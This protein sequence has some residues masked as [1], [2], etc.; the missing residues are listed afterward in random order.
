MVRRIFRRSNSAF[1][2]WPLGWFAR[3]E[4]KA[5]R[6]RLLDSI[7]D[8]V[9]GLPDTANIHLP[10]SRLIILGAGFSRPAGLPLA[11]GLLELVRDNLKRATPGNELER[12]IAEWRS[13][14]PNERLDLE[15]VLA[16]SH[17]RHHLRLWGPDYSEGHASTL[18]DDVQNQIQRILIGSTPV[19]PEIPAVYRK[20]AGLLTE[21]DVVLTF[22]YDTILEETLKFTGKPYSLVPKR[23]L[24]K[25]SDDQVGKPV[26]ILKLHGSVDWYD[27][28]YHDAERQWTGQLGILDCDPIF[29]PNP[30]V[31]SE[32]LSPGPFLQQPPWRKDNDLLTRVVRVPGL[33]DNFLISSS[34]Y[35]CAPFLLPPAHDKLLG[36]DPITDIWEGI[37]QGLQLFSGIVIIGYSF[38]IYDSYA[39]EGLG[40]LLLDYQG[41]KDQKVYGQS[42][43]PI[44][45]I[46]LAESQD[47]ALRGT[48]FL[49]HDKTR[50]WHK[51][52]STESVDWLD[53]GD[54]DE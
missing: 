26:E 13:L 4:P 49:A 52:F 9:E 6:D 48:P 28:K 50:V 39:Y 8:L 45:I 47:E 34:R 37:H 19:G 5:Y 36:Y 27:R 11:E 23:W 24:E 14:Y 29:G 12:E 16:Y 42:P 17:R 33:K 22:N 54:G 2:K 10:R 25:V 41:R 3:K 43:T 38:P 32:P 40:K 30:V 35:R 44:Q 1:R 15:R 46:T 51:E 20:F 21:H 18:I 7:M 53:W 31:K